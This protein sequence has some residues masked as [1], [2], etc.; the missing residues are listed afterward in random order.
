VV[1]L[2]QSAAVNPR[3]SRTEDNSD[4][5][6]A[7]SQHTEKAYREYLDSHPSG[8]HAAQALA[9]L[10]DLSY[11][12]KLRLA[13]LKEELKPIESQLEYYKLRMAE[14]DNNHADPSPGDSSGSGTD[15][16]SDV[17]VYNRI[18]QEYNAL[19]AQ[20]QPKYDEYKR[21]LEST[22]ADISR[23]NLAMGTR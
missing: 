23:V 10:D 22:N 18:V 3:N 5:Q 16:Y 11:R 4:F 20:Y 6:R 21:L 9:R 13:Q 14:L 8:R 7:E 1:V 12:A 2:W 19:L 15:H 17:G